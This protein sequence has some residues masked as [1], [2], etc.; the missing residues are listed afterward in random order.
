MRF[1]FATAGR[2]L[3]GPGTLSEIAPLVEEIGSSAL[4]ITGR[5]SDRAAPLVELLRAG[6]VS[7]ETYSLAGEPTVRGVAEGAEVARKGGFQVIIGFGGGSAI[8]A[9][10]AVAAF[11]TNPGDPFDHL[12]VVGK[13]LPLA[14]SPQPVVAVP[15]TAGT[16]AEVTRNAVLASEEHRAKVSLRSPN[17]LPRLAVV[18]PDLTLDLPPDVTASTG[19]DALTQLIEPFLSIRATPVTDALC[20]DGIPR[21]ARSL[22]R[23]F[24]NGSDLAARE[25]M[26][27]ASLFGGMALANSGLGVVHGFAAPIGGMFPAPHGAIC[28]A[29]L[30]YVMGVNT[31][32]LVERNP[33]AEALERFGE[34]ARMLTGDK[35][36]SIADGIRWM[37]NLSDRLSIPPLSRYGITAAHIPELVEKATR[38]SS[39][40]GN[41]ITLTENELSSIIKHAIKL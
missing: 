14:Q 31:K 35:D 7:C 40:K 2:I 11:A 19:M 6:G 32:A 33:G 22:I 39:T 28:A 13:G 24:E 25:D 34:V 12:E 1:E 18:D 9:A 26:A 36:A 17:L 27:L 30:P 37:R 3:F 20:R 5:R 21:I 4:I 23:V 29:L 41:P 8:D 38:A 16:G 15:T 10:K